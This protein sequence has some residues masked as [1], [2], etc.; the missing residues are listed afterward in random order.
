MRILY[1]HRSLGD[2]GEGVHIRAMIDAFRAR[3]VTLSTSTLQG[4]IRSSTPAP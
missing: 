2:G 1:M 4:A 3:A